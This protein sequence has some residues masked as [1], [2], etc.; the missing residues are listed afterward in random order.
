[1]SRPD[2]ISIQGSPAVEYDSTYLSD[3]FPPS[4][5]GGSIESLHPGD[6]FEFTNTLSG[7]EMRGEVQINN[8]PQDFTCTLEHFNDAR[9]RVAIDKSCDVPGEQS[10]TLFV[11]TYGL[12]AA[13]IE[14]LQQG[15]DA[16][17]E[18]IKSAATP[19]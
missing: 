1:M 15:L 8:P 2:A 14:E 7:L 17:L 16:A 4:P 19:S 5:S 12:D 18:S 13:R 6:H 9:L 10:V 11:S 3:P